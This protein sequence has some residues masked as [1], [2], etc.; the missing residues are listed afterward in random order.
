MLIGLAQ[1]MLAPHFSVI[2][3]SGVHDT[4]RV[5]VCCDAAH[6]QNIREHRSVSIYRD[7]APYIF[8]SNVYCAA[9]YLHPMILLW[10]VMHPSLLQWAYII[11]NI[12]LPIPCVPPANRARY[13][14]NGQLRFIHWASARR[15]NNVRSDCMSRDFHISVTQGN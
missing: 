13:I 5:C 12:F 3:L 14:K 6:S 7:I 10:F 11:H 8:S 2:F 9:G 1:Y 4:A 15:A